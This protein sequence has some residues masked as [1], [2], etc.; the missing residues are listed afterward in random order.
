MTL[1][2]Y[3]YCSSGR[4]YPITSTGFRSFFTG[5]ERYPGPSEF[6]FLCDGADRGVICNRQALQQGELAQTYINSCI[7]EAEFDLAGFAHRPIL[8]ALLSSPD[9]GVLVSDFAGVYDKGACLALPKEVEAL[10]SS[11]A[12]VFHVPSLT[13]R[14][15]T[16]AHRCVLKKKYWS[17]WGL[18]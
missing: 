10:K 3:K 16:T 6:L 7:R 14:V 4:N 5:F 12:I 9:D 15:S 13:Y 11:K 8:R 2:I 17:Y 18:G 1:S